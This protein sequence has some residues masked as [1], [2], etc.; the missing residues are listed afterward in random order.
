[1]NCILHLEAQSMKLLVQS[2]PLPAPS[3]S[4]PL[5]LSGSLQMR[6]RLLTA[7]PNMVVASHLATVQT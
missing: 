4:L 7:L 2:L 6:T 1:M 3:L 5:S